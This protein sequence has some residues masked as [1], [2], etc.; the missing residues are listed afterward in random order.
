MKFLKAL[1]SISQVKRESKYNKHLT[2]TSKLYQV[3]YVEGLHK[4]CAEFLIFAVY[5]NGSCMSLSVRV[6]CVNILKAPSQTVL[7]MAVSL[8]EL[9]IIIFSDSV[10]Q[11]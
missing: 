6:T 2:L 10:K 9:Y 4:S 7:K 11:V 1:I 3:R 5:A 8:F